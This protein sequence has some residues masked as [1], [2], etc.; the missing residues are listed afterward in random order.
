[1]TNN[2]QTST[3]TEGGVQ[4]SFE[5]ISSVKAAEEKAKK[6]IAEA[7]TQA[8]QMVADT[9]AKGEKDAL[10]AEDKARRE[11]A[12]LK[13]KTEELASAAAGETASAADTKK[14]VLKAKADS[15]MEKAAALIVERIVNA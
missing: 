15:R 13:V 11:L 1:M 12:E 6:I 8:K 3:L 4:M 5:S 14:A 9:E 10:E 7:Q 2:Q